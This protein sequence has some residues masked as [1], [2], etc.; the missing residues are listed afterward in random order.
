MQRAA[1]VAA[2]KDAFTPSDASQRKI[3]SKYG[4]NTKASLELGSVIECFY[5]HKDFTT[6]K[7]CINTA[8]AKYSTS[9][10]C[11][12]ALLEISP[13]FLAKPTCFAVGSLLSIAY[14]KDFKN[15]TLSESDL[16]STSISTLTRASE[17]WVPQYL[18][19]EYGIPIEFTFY[20]TTFVE[21]TALTAYSYFS[22]PS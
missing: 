22:T 15:E 4:I 5:K 9:F 8:T 21:G 19:Q 18:A 2:T 11:E 12:I 17:H 1:S 20:I 16:V 13:P 10:V 3:V 14:K 7:I 6:T